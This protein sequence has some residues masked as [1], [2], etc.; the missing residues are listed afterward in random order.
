V[1]TRINLGNYVKAKRIPYKC[2][3]SGL[4]I[5]LLVLNACGGR[6]GANELAVGK[7]AKTSGVVRIPMNA[8]IELDWK[9]RDDILGMREK[10]LNKFPQLMYDTYMPGE[11]F[12]LIEDGRPWWGLYGLHVYR[13]GQKAIDGPSKESEYL[14]N[15]YRLVAAEPNNIGIFRPNSFNEK[16]LATKDFPFAWKTGPLIFDARN[17][18]AQ[19]TY[20]VTGY[21]HELAK[22]IPHLKGDTVIQNFSL[23]AYNARDLAY[24]FMYLDAAKSKNVRAWGKNYAIEIPQMIHCGGSCGYPGGCNNMSPHTA[25]TDNN[26]LTG[27]PARAYLKLWSERPRDA[28]KD[29]ADF[30]MVIDFI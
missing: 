29:P 2:L 4:A 30:T 6:S 14:L 7:K 5:L 23:I 28:E 16:Q 1:A 27:L 13:Q 18:M 11:C 12:D 21:H 15:P 19:I 22:W 10:E 20:D 9:S 8:P 24:P 3:F 17:S 25:E 26:H